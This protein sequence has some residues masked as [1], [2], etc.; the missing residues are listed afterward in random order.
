M[1]SGRF[2]LRFPANRVRQVPAFI[3][4]IEGGVNGASELR[5]ASKSRRRPPGEETESSDGGL[6]IKARVWSAE[7]ANSQA[8]GD[9]CGRSRSSLR[10]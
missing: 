8:H 10:P 5:A 9:A 3:G 1:G 2:L 7:L 6:N 4:Y